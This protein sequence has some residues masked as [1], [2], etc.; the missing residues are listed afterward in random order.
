MSS[1]WLSKIQRKL[2]S[3]G[4]RKQ[5]SWDNVLKTE[6][7]KLYAGNLAPTLPQ[8]ATHYG[9]ALHPASAKDIQHDMRSSLSVPD[10]SI[11]VFQSEDVFE[12]IEYQKI[13]RILDEIFRVLRPDGLFRLSVPDYRC[14]LLRDR[15]IK[16]DKGNILF[17]PGGGGRF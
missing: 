15:S 16:D 2:V 5:A 9:L 17:D 4:H 8:F 12:H 13:G 1:K 6:D 14:P 10:S 11:A 3:V 7:P